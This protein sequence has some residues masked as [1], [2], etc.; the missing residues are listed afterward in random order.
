MATTCSES[1]TAAEGPTTVSWVSEELELLEELLELFE[2]LVGLLE[3]IVELR[4]NVREL[5]EE[6]EPLL[7]L[8]PEDALEFSERTTEDPVPEGGPLWMTLI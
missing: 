5:L 6:R 8:Q 1:R 2:E 7:L 3:E 4:G